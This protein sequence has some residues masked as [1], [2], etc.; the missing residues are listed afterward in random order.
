M[1]TL[2]LVLQLLI[3]LISSSLAQNLQPTDL[4]ALL[5][6]KATLTDLSPSNPFFST[7][8]LTAPDPCSS[9]AGLTCTL[10]R[11]TALSLGDPSFPL[12]GT[13]PASLSLLTDL[14]QLLLSPGLVTGSIPPHLAHL[15][16]LRV[17]SLPS[18]RLTGP[19]PAALSA[20]RR[21]HTLDLSRNQLS[22]SVP[23]TLTDLPQLK[24]LILA[25]NSLS[26]GLPQT[27][28]SPL[29]HLDLKDNKLTGPL[30]SFLP[31]S[32]RYLS[33]SQNLMWGPL[34]NGLQTLTE[35]AFLDLSMN[36]FAGPIPAQLLS[37]PALSNIFLQRNNLSGGL[38]SG[39]RP[40][41]R[42]G[43]IVDLSHNSLSG[44]LSSVLEGVESLFLNN[45]RF[46]GEVPE[47]Y[48][49]SV[50]RGTTR[51][52]Y[53]QH[54]YLTGIPL[55]EGAV[56]PDTASLCVSYNCMVPPPAMVVTCPASAGGEVARPAAQCSVFSHNRNTGD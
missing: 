11:V 50:W 38:G 26:D 43:S 34:P 41:P 10:R 53:L 33:L 45:N 2:L 47:A 31:S 51:L 9:F 49:K 32:L 3:L 27:V 24:I 40:G 13:L 4:T 7:W 6:I 15:T 30:P 8:N 1:A 54:N 35:L 46:S 12:A 39:T 56:L 52:L 17:L 48:V 36:R 28:N 18:N 14:T 44:E 21:L 22:G 5:S 23:P 42:P 55:R 20:L 37:L 19:I 25:S 29:L 16:N